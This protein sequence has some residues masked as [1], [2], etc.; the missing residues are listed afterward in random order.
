MND[1]SNRL[2]RRPRRGPSSGGG[3]LPA[4]R[5]LQL[6]ASRRVPKGYAGHEGWVYRGQPIGGWGGLVFRAE[7]SE[8]TAT[9]EAL[10]KKEVSGA[11]P[12]PENVVILDDPEQPVIPERPTNEQPTTPA[13]GVP[14]SDFTFPDQL[15]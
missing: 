10:E 8:E 7:E 11:A 3:G 9:E 2:S 6:P 1:T 15:D 13:L 12:V 5:G 4:V 14:A